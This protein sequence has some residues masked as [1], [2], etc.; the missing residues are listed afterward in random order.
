MN[1]KYI[2][3]LILVVLPI[4]VYSQEHDYILY[5]KHQHADFDYQKIDSLDLADSHG[6]DLL[7]NIFAAKEGHYTVY[8]YLNYDKGILYDDGPILD[9]IT[10][11]MIK[12]DDDNMIVDAYYYHLTNPEMPSSCRLY[13]M[14]NKVQSQETMDLEDFFFIRIVEI[15]SEKY[16]YSF[17]NCYC[18]WMS[19][20]Y[21]DKKG[22]LVIK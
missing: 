21:L 7:N 6:F 9:I 12:A 13:K 2:I 10:L 1:T 19:K 22:T 8:R 20:S 17:E 14:I 11:V 3:L 4:S 5:D 18:N 16:R 15:E